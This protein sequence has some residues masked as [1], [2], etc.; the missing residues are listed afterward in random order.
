MS[1]VY[2]YQ[3]VEIQQ[4]P[5][6]PK[7]YLTK[8][9]ARELLKWADV[10]RKRADFQ[11]GY[12]RQLTESRTESIKD[13]LEIDEGNLI[14][15]ALLVSVED[16]FFAKENKESE[17]FDIEVR[18]REDEDIESLI[19][20]KFESFYSRLGEREKKFADGELDVEIENLEEGKPLPSSYLSELTRE[21]K[22]A[23]EDFENLGSDRQD[24]VREY[25]RG[26]SKPGRILDG[27]HRVFG[28]KN[29]P[30]FDVYFPVVLMPGLSES[31]QVFHFFVVN[32]K[33]KPLTPVELRSTVSTSLTDQEI[34]NLYQ[35]FRAAG[36]KAEEAKLTY[37]MN[38][39][40][41]SPFQG[42]IDFGLDEEASIIPENVSNQVVLDFVKMHNNFRP[43]YEDVD[44]WQ[45][46]PEFDY[47]LMTFFAFW[48][49]IKD[50]YSK[51]WKKGVEDQ[52]GYMFYKVTLLKL[53]EIVL[54]RLVT[55]NEY[56]KKMM[57]AD[58]VLEDHESLDEMIKTILGQLP[59][60]FFL[61]EWQEKIE[62]SSDFKEYLKEQ[63]EKAMSG[64][65]VGRLGLFRQAG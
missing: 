62:D 6:G 4:Q 7:L 39:N 34:D 23:K 48:R 18:S 20:E 29:V 64:S 42:L 54:E 8:V 15:G 24:A 52:E 65:D 25:V 13:F 59:E 53:Q 49:S 56:Q 33:A 30:S 57:D 9:P 63:M 40:P 44:E 22:K 60:E 31:E 19:E 61:R 58:S 1:E 27:Q 11:A 14:P 16:N 35:R 47:R 32:N 36:V 51:A 17:Y 41:N 12:Q 5:Q 50:I 38:R 3:S 37:R 21:L 45:Q 46:D 55:M 26:M 2:S 10:P 43:L 28:A